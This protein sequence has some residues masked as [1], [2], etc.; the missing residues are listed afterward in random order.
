M[1]DI[2]EH[3]SLHLILMSIYVTAFDIDDHVTAS[4]IDEHICH[5]I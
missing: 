3:M 2:D 1:S 4:D 5:C